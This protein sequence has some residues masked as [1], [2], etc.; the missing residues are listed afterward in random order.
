MTLTGSVDKGLLEPLNS[1]FTIYNDHSKSILQTDEKFQIYAKINKEKQL[2]FAKLNFEAF[3]TEFREW[4]LESG[5]VGQEAINNKYK[6]LKKKY[7]DQLLEDMNE[8]INPSSEQ[9]GRYQIS[10]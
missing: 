9:D 5:D 8:L 1:Y 10:K 7:D 6:E 4:K 2:A 3:K